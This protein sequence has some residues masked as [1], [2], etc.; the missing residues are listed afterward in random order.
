MRQPHRINIFLDSFRLYS[1]LG[2]EVLYMFLMNDNV[3]IKKTAVHYLEIVCRLFRNP[4]A[5][6]KAAEAGND[7]MEADSKLRL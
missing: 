2:D 6:F 5:G 1:Y 3:M 4:H 7:G